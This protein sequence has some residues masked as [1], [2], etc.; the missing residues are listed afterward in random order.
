MRISAESLNSDQR[1]R[2]LDFVMSEP[3]HCPNSSEEITEKTL[4]SRDGSIQV[5][6]R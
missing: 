2:P 6:V 5:E 3:G 4:S 1:R